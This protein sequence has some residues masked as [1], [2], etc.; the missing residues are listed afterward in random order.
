MAKRPKLSGFAAQRELVAMAKNMDLDAIVRKTGR[1]PKAILESA[2]R[3][4][5]SIKG[6]K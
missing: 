6:R 3:L 4:G 1:S 2:R 5:I